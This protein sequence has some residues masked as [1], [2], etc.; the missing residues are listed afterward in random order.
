MKNMTHDQQRFLTTREL[1]EHFRI[2]VR[3]VHRWKNEGILPFYRIGPRM[4][5]FDLDEGNQALGIEKEDTPY[6]SHSTGKSSFRRRRQHHH[7]V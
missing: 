5:R 1:A 7:P 4:I 3:S 2:S 6:D